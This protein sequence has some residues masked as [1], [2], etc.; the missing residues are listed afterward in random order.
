MGC[1]Q[2]HKHALPGY[3]SPTR[4]PSIGGTL[5]VLSGL[6]FRLDPNLK[7]RF[8]IE[9]VMA[10]FI[11][12][13]TIHCIA[14]PAVEKRSIVHIT[15]TQNAVDYTHSSLQFQYEDAPQVVRISPSGGYIA[16]GTNVE[17]EVKIFLA[18]V[19]SLVS[20]ETWLACLQIM[21]RAI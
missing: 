18:V 20:L 9:D 7:C 12:S 19:E 1:H 21:S 15:L 2:A 16:G 4:G 17:L 5:V 3:V 11:N 10:T 13:T 6:N 8:G 14:P